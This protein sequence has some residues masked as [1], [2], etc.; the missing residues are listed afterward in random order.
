[1]IV[2][3][4]SKYGS[5]PVS[6]AKMSDLAPHR[7]WKPSEYLETLPWWGTI[8][9]LVTQLVPGHSAPSRVP[10]RQLPGP[11]L[12][13]PLK[14]FIPAKSHSSDKMLLKNAPSAVCHLIETSFLLSGFVWEFFFF[15]VNLWFDHCKEEQRTGWT[16][17]MRNENCFGRT[18]EE[19]QAGHLEGH[20]ARVLG[21]ARRPMDFH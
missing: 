10:G 3:V 16:G 7:K 18:N 17:M 13:N 6:T 5:L 1:M 9:C 11:P 4:T 15:F 12:K 14:K 20:S 8:L 21:R 2:A 19:M